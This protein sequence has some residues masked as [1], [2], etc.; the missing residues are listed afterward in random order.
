[1]NQALGGSGYATNLIQAH[2]G[3]IIGI[4]KSYFNP[5]QQSVGLY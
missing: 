1:M 4:N 5:H 2:K 3:I